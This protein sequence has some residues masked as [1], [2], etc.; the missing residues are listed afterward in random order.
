MALL[1]TQDIA[2]SAPGGSDQLE[3]ALRNASQI[4]KST[5]ELSYRVILFQDK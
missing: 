4:D 1:L 3:I 2:T 5:Y